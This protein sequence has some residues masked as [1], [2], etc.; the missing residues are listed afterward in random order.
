MIYNVTN[1]LAIR[2]LFKTYEMF[3]IKD[4][5]INILSICNFA[6]CNL[7]QLNFACEK[8]NPTVMKKLYFLGFML[9]IVSASYSV[10][11]QIQFLNEMSITPPTLQ[12]EEYDNLTDLLENS[13]T[14]PINS[15]NGG[16]QGTEVIRFS[17]SNIGTIEDITVINSVSDEIDREVIAVLQETSGKWDPGTIDG[18]PTTMVRELALSFVLFSYNNMLNTAKNYMQKGNKLMF[19]ECKPEKAIKYYD[20]AY[21]LFPC[22][23]SVLLVKWCCLEKLGRLEDASEARDRLEL[24]ENRNMPLKTPVDEESIALLEPITL[25][26]FAK[27]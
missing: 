20:M 21:T 2:L 8:I 24:L 15:I 7:S 18:Q 13:I 4:I 22:K 25:L 26:L 3:K 10:N 14:Y 16:L 19:L 9:V 1:E 11:A 12:N 17:V 27:K 5:I 23:P 6:K